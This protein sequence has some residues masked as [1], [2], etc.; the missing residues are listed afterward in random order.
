[1][2]FTRNPDKTPP[3]AQ[4]S[5]CS[6]CGN[7]YQQGCIDY[8]YESGES[9]CTDCSPC[10]NHDDES[11]AI[12]AETCIGGKNHEYDTDKQTVTYNRRNSQAGICFEDNNDNPKYD[13]ITRTYAC[14]RCGLPIRETYLRDSCEIAED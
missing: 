2:E 7:F 4:V 5:Q 10:C 8:K 13:A 1:M 14:L 12:T 9:I 11:C 3:T 6:Q